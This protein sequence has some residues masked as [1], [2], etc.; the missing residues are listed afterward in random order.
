[1]TETATTIPGTDQHKRAQRERILAAAQKRF[2]CSG[3]HSAS[4][5][6]IAETAGMSPGLI[7]RYFANKNAIILAIIEQQLKIAQ[8][9]IR[10]MRSTDDLCSGILDYFEAHDIEE[11]GAMSAALFLEIAAEATRDPE[12]AR[13]FSR[14]DEAVRAELV[15]WFCRGSTSGY[16]LD[17][18]AA[19][20]R[21]LSLTILIEGLKV[22]KARQPTL[23]RALL[24][25]AIE[26]LL[27]ALDR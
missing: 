20:R 14:F 25:D 19:R 24:K 22:R 4:M 12:I 13:A 10:D 11:D 26:G 8:R 21:A 6:T 7:Y 27:G 9:R 18:D 2:I 15:E 23:D 3:F 17:I 1:V 5:A 16:S